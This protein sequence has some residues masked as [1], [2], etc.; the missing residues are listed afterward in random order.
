MFLG[1][2]VAIKSRKMAS[3]EEF[4]ALLFTLTK[5][6]TTVLFVKEGGL[7]YACAYLLACVIVWLFF[8]EPALAGPVSAQVLFFFFFF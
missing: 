5:G 7:P 3:E 2:I 8:P 4:V 6:A 1:V